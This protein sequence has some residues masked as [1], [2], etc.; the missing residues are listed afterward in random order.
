[1]V[2]MGQRGASQDGHALLEAT[3][4]SLRGARVDSRGRLWSRAPHLDLR[5]GPS[6]LTR[7]LAIYEAIVRALAASGLPLGI[8]EEGSYVQVGDERLRI[9][10]REQTVRRPHEPTGKEL[11][12]AK[13]YGS[14]IRTDRW[15]HVPTG[16]FV[17][18]IEDGYRWAGGR[19]WTETKTKKMETLLDSIVEGL[20]AGAVIKR[21]NRLDR[22]RQSREYEAR[23]RADAE[24]QARQAQEQIRIDALVREVEAWQQARLIREYVAVIRA[25]VGVEIRQELHDWVEWA[26]AVAEKLD[27]LPRRRFGFGSRARLPRFER[28]ETRSFLQS[29]LLEVLVFSPLAP[30]LSPVVALHLAPGLLPTRD[31]GVRLAYSDDQKLL[32][33]TDR[34]SWRRSTP[35]ER[36]G[37]SA[38]TSLPTE[39]S[40]QPTTRNSRFVRFFSTVA[41][42]GMCW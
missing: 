34:G 5:V 26:V 8:S 27:P 15:D 3:R 13:R 21:E 30:R 6:G 1:M 42:A 40:S 11:A 22:E 4:K 16:E 10:L 23:R 14:P 17:F 9:A 25:T 36:S 18:V 35:V 37:P 41:T 33:T 31:R 2:D 12:D 19:Q 24:S 28:R 29:L 32:S 39:S 38:A 20:R 7:G